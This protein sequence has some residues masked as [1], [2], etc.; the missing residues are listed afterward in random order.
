MKFPTWKGFVRIIVGGKVVHEDHNL[1]TNNGLAML[2][3]A[4]MGYPVTPFYAIWITDNTDTPL[5]TDT[6]AE[7]CDAGTDAFATPNVDKP[8]RVGKKIYIECDVGLQTGNFNWKKLGLV[9]KNDILVSEK[10]VDIDTKDN[11]VTATIQWILE[12]A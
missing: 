12:V 8:Y 3:N 5:V 11:T 10:V 1:I 4:M 9:S 2:C 6:T 7:F